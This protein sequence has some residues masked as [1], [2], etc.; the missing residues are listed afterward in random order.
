[1]C[2][3]NG[4]GVDWGQGEEHTVHYALL[5]EPTDGAM[6]IYVDANFDYTNIQ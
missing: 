5:P 3:T 2:N 1:M 4:G 6:T